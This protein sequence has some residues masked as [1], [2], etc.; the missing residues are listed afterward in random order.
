MILNRSN[1]GYLSTKYGYIIE[2]EIFI[3]FNGV[4]WLSK[5]PELSRQVLGAD[6][7]KG[8]SKKEAI[9]NGMILVFKNQQD[10][11]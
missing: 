9:N 3:Q 6:I 11:P 2:L 7:K 1:I 10:N 5:I 4:Y 8:V